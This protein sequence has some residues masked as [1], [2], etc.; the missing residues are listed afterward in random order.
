MVAS[1]PGVRRSRGRARWLRLQADLA[2]GVLGLGLGELVA[3]WR[4]EL[5]DQA[6]PAESGAEVHVTPGGL[7]GLRVPVRVQVADREFGVSGGEPAAVL[8]RELLYQAGVAEPRS[9]VEVVLGG[10][11]R[12]L[13]GH[14][15][16]GG[17][18]RGLA[19]DRRSGRC[20]GLAGRR[21]AAAAR[22]ADA[23]AEREAQ[24]GHGEDAVADPV[25]PAR[26][27]R[28]G[29]CVLLVLHV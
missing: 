8:G 24:A 6:G 10:A 3:V 16:P 18:G 5:L 22:R 12:L 27:L 28:G 15:G 25:S 19:G 4:G 21:V 9:Q 11:D 23:D 17:S 13:L 29:I 2:G 26:A 7:C 14:C 1:G 20:R